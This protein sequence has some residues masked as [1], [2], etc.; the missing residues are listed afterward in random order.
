MGKGGSGSLILGVVVV[1]MLAEVGGAKAMTI[2]SMDST[3]LAECLPAIRG[4][5]PSPPSRECC[6]V[7]QK[8]DLH[9]LCNYKSMLPTYGV[10]PGLAM[11]LPKLC[12][13]ILPPEC[14]RKYQMWQFVETYDTA[15][16]Y[17]KL[18]KINLSEVEFCLAFTNNFDIFEDESGKLHIQA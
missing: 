6:A 17:E 5:S 10:N 13:L 1:A 7:L 12:G 14:S 2:C 8:A 9:C 16:E 4:F 11:G 18:M 3:E 15:Y